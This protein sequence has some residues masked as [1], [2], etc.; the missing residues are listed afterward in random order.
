ME[1]VHWEAA[2]VLID[3]RANR[4]RALSIGPVAAVAIDAALAAAA[5]VA[6]QSMNAGTA[7]WTCLSTR[8]CSLEIGAS[9]F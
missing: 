4:I 3:R 7:Y 8:H 6:F 1:L 2:A 9:V 5:A